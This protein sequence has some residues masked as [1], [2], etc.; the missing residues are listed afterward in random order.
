LFQQ[1]I[2]TQFEVHALLAFEMMSMVENMM[3]I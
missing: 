2:L 3:H 1:M